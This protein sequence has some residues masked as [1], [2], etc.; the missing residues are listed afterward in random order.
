MSLTG[1]HREYYEEETEAGP[2]DQQG[3]T[4]LRVS[5]VSSKDQSPPEDSGESEA[6]LECSF[7]AAHSSAP[8]T[9]PGPHLTMTAAS[10]AVT[11]SADKSSPPCLPSRVPKYRRA[12]P[13]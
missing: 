3:D 11:Q 1:M 8:Q 5:S 9:D 7:A 2:E 13:A 6:E 12:F 10:S 4:Y